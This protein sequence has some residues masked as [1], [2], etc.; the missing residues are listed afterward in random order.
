MTP[1]PAPEAEVPVELEPGSIARWEAEDALAATLDFE[2]QAGAPTEEEAAAMLSKLR[3]TLPAQVLAAELVN[4][5]VERNTPLN[6]PIPADLNK[7]SYYLVEVPV[8]ILAPEHKLTRLCLS[9]EFQS[10][11]QS[12]PVAY[13]LFPQD[14]ALFKE[15]ELGEIKV[16]VSKALSF[17]AGKALGDVLGLSL[18]LP[19][20]W[21]SQT[22]RIETTDRMSNPL[23]WFVADKSIQQGFTGYAIVR[24][25]K[26][27]DLTIH[28]KL[29]CEVRTSGVGG[30]FRKATFVSRARSYP[31]A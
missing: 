1:H 15:T 6:L 10:A 16:D 24:V 19:L 28:A 18:K 27:A 2:P 9:L 26:G 4:W 14:A 7:Y 29:A 13:D 11:A 3:L 17:V 23:E 8:N 30:I 25:P 12:T 22:V 21:T 20:K 5:A 31:I